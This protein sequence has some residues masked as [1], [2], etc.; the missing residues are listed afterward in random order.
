MGIL[1]IAAKFH[2]V[3][4]HGGL[5]CFLQNNVCKGT[6]YVN[7]GPQI[8]VFFWILLYF[9]VGQILFE[10]DGIQSVT[11][12]PGDPTVNQT[13]NNYN[14]PSYLRLCAE[15]GIDPSSDF[16]YKK[17]SNHRLGM[18][19]MCASGPTKLDLPYSSKFAKF[20]NKGSET[21]KG[22]LCS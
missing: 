1:G 5:Q 18:V 2:S 17:D 6:D 11:V 21:I 12:L 8:R 14:S 16:H 9:M 4:C 13:N 7:L 3:V 20:S 10:M 19:F 15:F 22:R